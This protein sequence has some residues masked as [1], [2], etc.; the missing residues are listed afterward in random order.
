MEYKFTE[1]TSKESF[2]TAAAE[3]IA[4]ILKENIQTKG[5]AT[6]ILAGGSTPRSI[7]AQLSTLSDIDWS[8]VFMFFGDERYVPHDDPDS[9][10]V[11]VRASL[12]DKVSIPKENVFAVRT[13]MPYEHCI[14]DYEIQIRSFF[15]RKQVDVIQFDL[16]LLGLGKDGHIASLF[17]QSKA[18]DEELKLVTSSTTDEFKVRERITMTYPALLSATHF[19]F[20]LGGSNKKNILDKT[21]QST[22][23]HQFPASRILETGKAEIMAFFG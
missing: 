21:S 10:Y 3:R 17:P 16:I 6:I 18:L 12:I 20:F 22:D 19:L 14:E 13:E 4:A 11:M 9:N 2:V 15:S 7:Y 8:K 5:W 1:F 23:Y